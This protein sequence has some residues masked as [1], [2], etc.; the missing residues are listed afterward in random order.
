MPISQ[1]PNIEEPEAP[2]VK[3]ATEEAGQQPTATTLPKAAADRTKWQA[4]QNDPPQ[5]HDK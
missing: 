4:D 3:Q 5:A 2:Q 1:V